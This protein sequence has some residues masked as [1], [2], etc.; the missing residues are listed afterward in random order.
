M[1]SRRV[2]N[3]V[4]R[5]SVTCLHCEVYTTLDRTDRA[6]EVCLDYLRHLGIEWSPHPTPEEARHEYERTWELLGRREI[7]DLID[8]PLMSDPEAEATMEVLARASVPTL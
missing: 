5:A 8:L 4:D 3:P 7:E 6:V 2:V 1:V